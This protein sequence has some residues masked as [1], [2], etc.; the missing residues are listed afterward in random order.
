MK[1][2]T[3]L[4]PGFWIAIVVGL[5]LI[6]IFVYLGFRYSKCKKDEGKPCTPSTLRTATLGLPIYVG[7]MITKKKYKCNFW[8]GKKC[9]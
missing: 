1:N 7:N 2:L 3:P 4:G 6:G 8:K 5:I 9:V